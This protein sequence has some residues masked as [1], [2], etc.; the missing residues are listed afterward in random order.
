VEKKHTNA[1]SEVSVLCFV[2]VRLGVCC[3][4]EKRMDGIQHCRGEEASHFIHTFILAG[5]R[6][7]SE[8]K[9]RGEACERSSD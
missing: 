2:V 9:Q 1:M 5:A 6:H 8:M 3:C 7:A 4:S